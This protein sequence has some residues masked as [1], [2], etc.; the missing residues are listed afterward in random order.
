MVWEPITMFTSVFTVNSDIYALGLV[1]GLAFVG[2]C[3]VIISAW[4]VLSQMMAVK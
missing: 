2:I 1:S 3:L 4:P